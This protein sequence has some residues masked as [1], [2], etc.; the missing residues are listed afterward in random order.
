[1]EAP[2]R[3]NIHRELTSGSAAVHEEVRNVQP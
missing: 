1:M 2:E 3:E